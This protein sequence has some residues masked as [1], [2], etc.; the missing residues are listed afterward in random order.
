MALLGYIFPPTNDHGVPFFMEYTLPEVHHQCITR[1]K[2]PHWNPEFTI[3]REK[4]APGVPLKPRSRRSP[5][6]WQNKDTIVLKTNT[7]KKWNYFR[8]ILFSKLMRPIAHRWVSFEES[9]LV[10]ILS[11]TLGSVMFK[12]LL[13]QSVECPLSYNGRCHFLCLSQHTSE[14][15]LIYYS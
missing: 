7:Q 3:T 9:C 5:E 8:G 13:G 12:K 10:H 11:E 1:D 4:L 15:S 2:G 14:M 6:L